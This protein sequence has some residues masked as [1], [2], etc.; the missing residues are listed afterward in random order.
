MNR[1]TKI[2]IRKTM[3]LLTEKAIEGRS[4]EYLEGSMEGTKDG[5]AAII[6]I[7]RTFEEESN[8]L[9]T[10]EDVISNFFSGLKI[11]ETSG[12]R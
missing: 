5:I 7:A 11:D 8:K 4:Q 6:D 9:A 1:E 2:L 10:T 12:N 3:E